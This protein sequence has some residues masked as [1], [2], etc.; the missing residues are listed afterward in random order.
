MQTNTRVSRPGCERLTIRHRTVIGLIGAFCATAACHPDAPV[1]PIAPAAADLAV[2]N[3]GTW[4]VNSLADPGDGTCSNTE[5]TLREAIAAAQ[6]GDRIT[7]KSNLAGTIALTTGALI[8]EK[9]LTIEGP[10]PDVLV[11]DAQ[12]ASPV[13]QLGLQGASV[14]LTIFGLT[15][16]RGKDSG[17]T[18]AFDEVLTLI[19]SV[20]TSSQAETGGGIYS[21]GTVRI[22]GSTISGNAANELGGGI[23]SSGPVTITRSTISGNSAGFRGGGSYITCVPPDCGT[24]RL[25]SSTITQNQADEGGGLHVEEAVAATVLNTIIAGNHVLDEFNAA[26]A[27]CFASPT[28]LI[29]V[30]YNLTTTGTGCPTNPTDVILQ[31]PS[32]V[33][34]SVLVPVLAESGS[35]RPTHALIERGL[36]VDVGYCPGENADQRG[37]PRPYDDPRMS[38]A[39]DACDIGAFEWNPLVT[40]G[41]GPKP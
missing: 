6:P 28:E 18:V 29:S 27:D 5:C 21:N 20:V 14:S 2:S 16:T 30:G 36:A 26:T 19:G 37:F 4:L 39:V 12:L 40:K 1:A 25:Q 17:I 8:I 38:N 7:F 10:A 33:F 22:I 32:Q 31:A 13:F 23:Y 15:I 41:K 35:S 11:V 34:A 3:D 9:T 24:V